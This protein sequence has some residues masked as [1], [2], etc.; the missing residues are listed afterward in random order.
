MNGAQAQVPMHSSDTG[1]SGP[2]ATAS[3]TGLS[4]PLAD[5]MKGI[6]CYLSLDQAEIRLRGRSSAKS[7]RIGS[8]YAL[9]AWPYRQ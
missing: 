8:D 9:P 3:D 6:I 4:G 2:P 1:L 7:E 5:S